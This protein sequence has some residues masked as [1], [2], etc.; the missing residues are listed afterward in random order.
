LIP[1]PEPAGRGISHADAPGT[2][3]ACREQ[4]V[5]NSDAGAGVPGTASEYGAIADGALAWPENASWG[6]TGRA[7]GAGAEDLVRAPRE[8]SGAAR[9]AAIPCEIMQESKPWAHFWYHDSE[10]SSRTP[11]ASAARET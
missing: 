4:R 5:L 10:N 9:Q 8:L 3:P 6:G 1:L 2:P 7:L 11:L